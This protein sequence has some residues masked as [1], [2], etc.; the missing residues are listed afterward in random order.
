MPT[1]RWLFADQGCKGPKL[2]NAL[3]AHSIDDLLKIGRK[4][5]GEKGF[6]V[7]PRRWAVERTFGWVAAAA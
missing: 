7:I 6:V 1:L 2:R 3:L 5:S 4:P